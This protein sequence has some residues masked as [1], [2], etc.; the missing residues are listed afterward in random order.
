V[1][2]PVSAQTKEGT[3]DSLRGDV[4]A[5]ATLGSFA[6]PNEK[7][8]RKRWRTGRPF[9]EWPQKSEQ[10]EQLGSNQREN[11]ATGKEGEADHRRHKHSPQKRKKWSYACRLV[12]KNGLKEGA[13][14]RQGPGS[15]SGHGMDK[16]VNRRVF[17]EYFGLAY[18]P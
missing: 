9:A 18:Q 12:G 16:W 11:R 1:E 4:E 8:K 3:A 17:S 2:E 10:R 15:I 14:H 13:S 5:P 7:K 6:S